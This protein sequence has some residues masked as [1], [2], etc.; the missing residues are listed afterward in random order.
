MKKFLSLLALAFVLTGVSPV[1]AAEEDGLTLD[2][3]AVTEEGAAWAD[4][5]AWWQCS[6]QAPRLIRVF[7]V[8][9]EGY[10]SDVQAQALKECNDK[11][12]LQCWPLGCHK[13]RRF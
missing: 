3:S 10:K 6:A 12:V 13:L 9:A 4:D 7:T 8:R 11:A 5:F 1:L 2:E